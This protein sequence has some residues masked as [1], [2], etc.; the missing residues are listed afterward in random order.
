[1]SLKDLGTQTAAASA[2]QK[3]IRPMAEAAAK[4]GVL[5][6]VASHWMLV[7]YV[8]LNDVTGEVTQASKDAINAAFVAAIPGNDDDEAP[9]PWSGTKTVKVN[10]VDTIVPK[11]VKDAR[12]AAQ[13]TAR[14]HLADVA[15]NGH[16]N[17]K[18]V[19]VPSPLVTA[20]IN[21]ADTRWAPKTEQERAEAAFDGLVAKVRK[22]VKTDGGLLVADNLRAVERG[23]LTLASGGA[24]GK[25][26]KVPAA[27]LVAVAN[28]LEGFDP[29]WIPAEQREQAIGVLNGMADN[30]QR[31]IDGLTPAAPIVP[32]P[33]GTPATPQDLA[34]ILAA[35]GVSLPVAAGQ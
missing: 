31:I 11:T 32:I 17:E 8:L 15:A 23:L 5:S 34:S 21:L 16:T 9:A 2:L 3:I 10:G 1:M 4:A 6:R 26:R 29:A 12:R 27:P 28:V 25:G 22:T 35:L 33:T 24:D 14:N 18:G 20:G 13:S 7:I 30:I 19:F